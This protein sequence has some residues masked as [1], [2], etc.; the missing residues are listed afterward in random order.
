MNLLC[1]IVAIPGFE[2]TDAKEGLTCEV[3]NFPSR[4]TISY[5]YSCQNVVIKKEEKYRIGKLS[6]DPIY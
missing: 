1:P 6:K 4:S 2:I 3:Y 5:I